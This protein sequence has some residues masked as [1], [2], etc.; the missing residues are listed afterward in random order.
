M[1][2]CAILPIP[3]HPT[4]I[5]ITVHLTEAP[6]FVNGKLGTAPCDV[7]V[8]GVIPYP[9][10]Y[11]TFVTVER[12]GEGWVALACCDVA[13]LDMYDVAV[14]E[15]RWKGEPVGPYGYASKILEFER[16]YG[17]RIKK[18]L[19]TTLGYVPYS[20]L[21]L[22][23]GT[24]NPVIVVKGGSKWTIST[25]PF[26]CVLVVGRNGG[27]LLVKDCSRFDRGYPLFLAD[28]VVVP[29]SVLEDDLARV[30]GSV[31]ECV[32]EAAPP[33]PDFRVPCIVT[34]VRP[35]CPE[36]VEVIPKYLD[37]VAGL[38]KLPTP[39]GVVVYEPLY[40]YVPNGG[41]IQVPLPPVGVVVPVYGGRAG[42]VEVRELSGGSLK[43][44]L[45]RLSWKVSDDEL[46]ISFEETVS[47]EGSEGRG[48]AA[49][50]V[51]L[52]WKRVTLPE[53]RVSRV[54]QVGA[55]RYSALLLVEGTPDSVVFVNGVPYATGPEGRLV[56]SVPG[57]GKVR[58][59]GANGVLV[60]E[61]SGPGVKVDFQPEDD[62]RWK[63]RIEA[64]WEPL[65]F[66]E[67]SSLGI[68]EYV[69][70]FVSPWVEL[71]LEGAGSS[72]LVTAETAD[73]M[74]WKNTYSLPLPGCR[75]TSYPWALPVPPIPPSRRAGDRRAEPE[76]SGTS[77][78][79]RGGRERSH[80]GGGREGVCG[81]SVGRA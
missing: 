18:G 23:A 71:D 5:D 32:I 46:V 43:V 42:I 33:S 77:P 19:Y 35:G 34:K 20:L 59:S 74:V 58:V 30:L 40:R 44:E 45:D 81:G 16:K 11:Q 17:I 12:N 36:F 6:V 75:A 56:I 63:M 53:G 62:R 60:T 67:I 41:P 39:F 68:P 15:G 25:K 72:V 54:L 31:G 7:T 22:I 76:T 73:G 70:D 65:V 27:W 4:L 55:D 3:C 61:T 37:P 66:L 51:V 38:T 80:P 21:P 57:F 29:V 10:Y 8:S 9:D 13:T 64:K 69:Y 79:D 1:T 26:H 49:G 50:T 48:K 24:D 52:R 2:I 14:E 78:D 47:I 28:Y